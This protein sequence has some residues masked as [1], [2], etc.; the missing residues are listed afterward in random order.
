M[1]KG[2]MGNQGVIVTGGNT[3]VPYVS[4]NS[5]NPMQGMVRVHGSDLQVFDGNSWLTMSTSYATASLDQDTQDLLQ[6]ARKKKLDEEALL[7]LPSDHPAVKS[8]RQNLNNAKAEVK[9][10]EEQLRITE[11]LSKEEH[12]KSTS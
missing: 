4:Q 8:A 9:R 7:S 1:I 11:I 6:W 12:E 5:N 3:S 2:L 10:L